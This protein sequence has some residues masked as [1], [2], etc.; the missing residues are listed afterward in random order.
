MPAKNKA[1]ISKAKEAEAKQQEAASQPQTVRELE[2]QRYWSTN[3]LH[4]IVEEQ[5]F[6]KLSP[7]DKRTYLNLELVRNPGQVDKLS[8][9]GQREL[10]KQ[11]SDANIPLRGTP[12]P[13]DDQWGYDKNGRNIGDYT[14]EEYGVYEQKKSRIS[15]L[16]LE[17]TFFKVNRER[18]DLKTKNEATGEIYTLTKDDIEAEKARRQE[19]AGLRNELYG[20]K[21]NSY[22][23]DPDWDDVVPIP[24]EEPE[25]ALSAIAYADDYAE[26]MSY[27]R[28]VMAVKEHTPRC[29]Q[30]TEAI[31]DM[32]PSHYTVW[33]Y[34]FDIVKALNI[35]IRTELEW[36][37][38]VS[39]E[40]LKNYQIWHHR[41]QLVDLYYP[42]IQADEKAISAFALD[43]HNFLMQ[44]LSKDTKNYHVWC[45]RQYLVRKLS[46]WESAYEA[47]CIDI[48]LDQDVRNNSAWSHRFFIIFSK[49]AQTTPD[50][51][52]TESVIPISKSIIERETRYAQ[53]KILLAP[54]NQSPWNYLRGVLTKGEQPLVTVLDF[55]NIFV[56]NL[57]EGEENEEVRSSHALDLLADI[58]KETGEKEMADLCLRRLGEKWD[59]IREGYWAYRRRMLEE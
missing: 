53:E 50:S 47:N 28:A 59:R 19:M 14:L 56:R 51:L 39:F 13:R 15:E 8:K 18:S 54:Q 22:A 3:P 2:W 44:M 5:G 58:Y 41:Q 23:Q 38:E 11:L 34:R 40:H 55:V 21:P 37:N 30:L 35:S 32:N 42:E 25:G 7:A 49:P 36:L 24:Q 6:A 4:K 43:E 16:H 1:G 26:A 20:V 33:L 52:A 31:I 27:L 48:M 29:L 46:Q 17:S 10:W 12:R 45:Y 57:G 9:K